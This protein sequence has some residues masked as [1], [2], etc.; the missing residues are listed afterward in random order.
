[1][2]KTL[3]IIRE[4]KYE[5]ASRRFK[6]FG[7]VLQ[8][9]ARVDAC[10][11]AVVVAKVRYQRAFFRIPRIV[12]N[13]HFDIWACPATDLSDPGNRH[14][15][16][17]VRRKQNGKLHGLADSVLCRYVHASVTDSSQDN[18]KPSRHDIASLGNRERRCQI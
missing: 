14:W 7:I 18:I 11:P 17:P 4:A 6:N 13:N 9:F 3:V 16:V 8:W 2:V 1:M 10:D 12:A 15:P 5:I